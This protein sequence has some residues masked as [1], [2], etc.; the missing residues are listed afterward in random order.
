METEKIQNLSDDMKKLDIYLST[1][2]KKDNKRFITNDCPICQS[3]F[4]SGQ[5]YAKA[6][7]NHIYHVDCLDKWLS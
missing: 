1:V 2:R 7:C 3:K 5:E 4:R 6:K